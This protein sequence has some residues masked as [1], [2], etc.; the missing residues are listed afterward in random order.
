M[1]DG[2]VERLKDEQLGLKLGNTMCFGEG[3]PFDYAVRSA[4]TV[5][6][7]VDVAAPLSE[8]ANRLFP[9][10][11]RSLASQAVIHL[12]DQGTTWTRPA[13]RFCDERVLQ[14]PPGRRRAGRRAARVLVPLPDPHELSDYQRSSPTRH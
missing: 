1:L 14:D 3:G 6:E 11:V 5:R 2:G 10:L 9:D 4:P 13:A 7:S 8:A 12:S